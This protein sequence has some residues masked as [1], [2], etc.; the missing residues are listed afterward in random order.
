MSEE[1]ISGVEEVGKEALDGISGGVSGIRKDYGDQS[2]LIVTCGYKCG[3]Y[4]K[5]T[6]NFWG[7]KTDG[8]C[9]SCKFATQVGVDT[10]CTN[11]NN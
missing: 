6:N 9:A 10:L 3:D 1:K 7:I 4:A 11:P 5:G 2:C 8:T